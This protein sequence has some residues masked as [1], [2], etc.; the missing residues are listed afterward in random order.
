MQGS[1][2]SHG[3]DVILNDIVSI[4]TKDKIPNQG[5]KG[6]PSDLNQQCTPA[7]RTVRAFQP[8]T[9]RAF[10]QPYGPPSSPPSL[11]QD[12]NTDCTES[13][14]LRLSPLTDPGFEL[15]T[16]PALSRPPIP[17][18]EA[19]FQDDFDRGRNVAT[20]LCCKPSE[21]A[22]SDCNFP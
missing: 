8:T 2:A 21:V 3:A 9:L 13:T 14:T 15:T 22:S 5:P 10:L 1:H 16:S 11:S 6:Q 19:L 4:R 20:E 17:V 7:I 18:Q 12:Y